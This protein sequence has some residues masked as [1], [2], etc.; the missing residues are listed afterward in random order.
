MQD[1][2]NF[3][4]SNRTPVIMM[5][6][7]LLY[8][9]GKNKKSYNHLEIPDGLTYYSFSKPFIHFLTALSDTPCFLPTATHKV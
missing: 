2:G 4:F 7:N 1:V 6:C 9:T 5:K 8:Y 3:R